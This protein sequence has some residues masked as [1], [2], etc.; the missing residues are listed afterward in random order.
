[1]NVSETH[2][3]IK[4]LEF[5]LE[6]ILPIPT[7]TLEKAIHYSVFNGGKR[8]RPQLVYATGEALGYPLLD[9]DAAAASVELMHC[10]SLV[11][12]D[13][14]AMD[15][16]DFRRGKPSCHKAFDEATAILTGDALQS[17]AF[18]TL[19][20]T[21][22]LHP[23]NLLS[24]IRV[25]AKN[26]GRSGM[27]AGQALDMASMNQT[28]SVEKLC[29]IHQKKTG[30]LIEASVL[31]GA[32]SSPQIVPPEMLTHFQK[33]AQAIGLSFQIQD[34]ILD[35]TSDT[36]TLGK[37]AGKDLEQ[38]KATFPHLLGLEASRQRA[39]ELHETA[40]DAIALFGSR[41]HQLAR[42]SEHF[43]ARIR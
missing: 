16:D 32:L 41:G 23:T 39:L 29:D 5:F 42:L 4:R 20:N 13:L 26:S 27:V 10:Y 38:N 7:T 8:L 33:Y 1:M 22:S 36:Q 15:D 31:L 2:T 14:P 9:L 24:M 34:D 40:L 21:K 37:T 12:D 30:A 19:A 18:E 17:L 35:I 28:V 25:L 43:I 6:Q 3:S 11:H